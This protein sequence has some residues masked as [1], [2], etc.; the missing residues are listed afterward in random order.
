ME[1][2][3]RYVQSQAELTRRMTPDAPNRVTPAGVVLEVHHNRFGSLAGSIDAVHL[4]NTW[5]EETSSFVGGSGM[6]ID[7]EMTLP[8]GEKDAFVYVTIRR[9][10]E[11]I[12]L[13][14]NTSVELDE[15]R[16][17][18]AFSIERLDLAPGEYVIDVGVY[19]SDWQTYDY[20]YGAYPFSVTGS[21]AGIGLIAPPMS[22]RV[23][24]RAVA[25]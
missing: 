17:V 10:D 7:I 11:I 2:T 25:R 1:V 15:A 20:H 18:V 21:P 23:V 5:M 3:A 12:C 6:N 8:S 13:D 19:G 4:R 9:A 22:W 24:S 14:A 16:G